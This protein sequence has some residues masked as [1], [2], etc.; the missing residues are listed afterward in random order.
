MAGFD[1]EMMLTSLAQLLRTALVQNA[2]LSYISS[3]YKLPEQLRCYPTLLEPAWASAKILQIKGD[4]FEARLWAASLDAGSDNTRK[5]VNS[6]FLPMAELAFNDLNGT[7]EFNM[8]PK[9]QYAILKTLGLE[10]HLTANAGQESAKAPAQGQ[11][12]AQR[13]CPPG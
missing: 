6:I 8:V 1:A 4:V 13:V 3:A 7:S 10:K 11:N 5:F 9:Q 12:E 2:T